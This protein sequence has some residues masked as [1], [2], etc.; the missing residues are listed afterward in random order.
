MIG[1]GADDAKGSQQRASLRTAIELAWW[2]KNGTGKEAR[3][4]LRA[5]MLELNKLVGVTDNDAW[6]GTDLKELL[7][8]AGYD[9]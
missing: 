8:R 7:K 1:F 9:G 2:A 6:K 5:H 3:R 4:A